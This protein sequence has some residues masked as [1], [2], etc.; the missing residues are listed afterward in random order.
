MSDDHDDGL[1]PDDEHPNGKK[2]RYRNPPEEYRWKSPQ[3]G[4]RH[5]RPKGSKNR[6]KEASGEDL[7]TML[8]EEGRRLMIIKDASGP[9]TLTTARVI[10]RAQGYAALKGSVRA[11]RDYLDSLAVAQNQEKRDREA[12]L[13]ALGELKVNW[14]LTREQYRKR[15][16]KP[17]KPLIDPDDMTVD[18]V[19]QEVRLREPA[20]AEETA[21]WDSYRDACERWLQQV[22]EQRDGASRRRRQRIL[23]DL[24]LVEASLNALRGALGGS[25][26]AMLILEHLEPDLALMFPEGE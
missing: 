17:P 12:L 24:T 19:S 5:G 23:E 14:Y 2:G 10:R 4:N 18:P 16:R 8:I 21:R 11:M 15:G 13:L 3:S 22:D 26:E 20:T 7:R 25:R 1:P 9:L 6:P